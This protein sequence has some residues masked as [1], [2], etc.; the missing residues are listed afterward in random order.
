[1]TENIAENG[2]VRNLS[3]QQWLLAGDHL[4]IGELESLAA[5][6]AEL[7]SDS[8]CLGFFRLARSPEACRARNRDAAVDGRTR[9]RRVGEVNSNGDNRT[10]READACCACCDSSQSRQEK[11][12]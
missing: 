12:E 6:I 2:V 5:G 10:V 9:P 7:V 4:V 8:A 3:M 1:M 11:Q